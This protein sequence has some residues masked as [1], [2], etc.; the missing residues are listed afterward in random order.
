MSLE[1]KVSDFS[2]P[3]TQFEIRNAP[4]IIYTDGDT[5][6]LKE[7][8][9]V[10]VVGSR[11]PTEEGRRRAFVFAKTLVDLGIT[12]VSGLAEGIDTI[13]H[14][15]AIKCKGRTI[16]VLG[17]SFD[18]VYPLS[19]SELLSVIKTDHLAVTQFPVGYPS[20]PE[21]FPRRNRTMALICDAT[22][23]I[24]AT[25]KSGTRHQGWEALRIGRT[26]FLL[27]SVVNNPALTWPKEMVKYGALVINREN[28]KEALI[29]LPRFTGGSD[30]DF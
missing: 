17:T 9:R 2:G 13:A 12:V 19:N 20:K 4:D 27:E 30:I 24:E 16:A 21:N 18:N 23:I 8:V 22:V 25:E 1:L 10:A 3:L 14:K 26:V 6:L 29:E 5:A 7:G 11:K 15:T 28:L